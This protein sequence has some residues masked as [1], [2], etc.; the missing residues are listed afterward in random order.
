MISIQRISKEAKKKLEVL[1]CT[2]LKIGI[3]FKHGASDM[4]ILFVVKGLLEGLKNDFLN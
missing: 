4:S 3:K 1:R 2:H